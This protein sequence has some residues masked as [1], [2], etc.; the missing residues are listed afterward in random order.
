MECETRGQSSTKASTDKLIF[1]R[2]IDFLLCMP[3]D[4]PNRQRA[5]AKE[6]QTDV[7]V[8]GLIWLP[9]TIFQTFEL[10]RARP[11]CTSSRLIVL[12]N[13]HI[14][15]SIES[16]AKIVC[17]DVNTH[18]F[19]YFHFGSNNIGN[20]YAAWNEWK[21]FRQL[22][23]SLVNNRPTFSQQMNEIESNDSIK[24]NQSKYL[25]FAFHLP[26]WEMKDFFDFFSLSKL[27][28]AYLNYVVYISFSFPKKRSI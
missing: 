16:I 7:D 20:Q 19:R 21:K 8:N 5:I 13:S 9:L 28:R 12:N 17:H 6:F 3:T 2:T 14:S 4:A 23:R 11:V 10:S 24:I 26:K 25:I 1:T 27:N 15:D 22:I 18:N